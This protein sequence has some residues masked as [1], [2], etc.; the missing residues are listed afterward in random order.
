MRSFVTALAVVL[1]ASCSDVSSRPPDAP[2]GSLGQALAA[3]ICRQL[4]ED[5][6]IWEN[7]IY[8]AQP[9]LCAGEKGIMTFRKWSSQFL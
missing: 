8:R 6:P 2:A 4:D 9:V 5:I 7:K 3:E 1:L